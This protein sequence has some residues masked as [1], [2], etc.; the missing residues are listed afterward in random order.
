MKDVHS[1]HSYQSDLLEESD[2]DARLA[3]L[4]VLGSWIPIIPFQT[5]LDHLAPPQ[6]D[7]DLNST[8]QSLK[9]GSEPVLTSSNRWS[10]FAEGSEDRLS[11]AMP[12][13]FTEVV[14]AIVANSGG[15]LNED[16]RTVEFLENPSRALTMAER[17]NKSRPDGYL[18]L[19]DREKAMSKNGKK[20]DIPW[21]D[22]ALSCEYKRNDGGDDSDL[23]DVRIHRGL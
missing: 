6:P 13:I 18:V 15:K 19:K 9:L 1:N 17:R 21:A 7:F 22:I 14:V 10:K 2:E 4:Q 3:V 20:E 11:S 16:K 5:F 8:M 12:E 23:D